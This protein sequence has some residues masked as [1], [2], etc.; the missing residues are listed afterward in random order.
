MD[1]ENR[2]DVHCAD[3]ED[4]H[5]AD[6]E[7]VHCADSHTPI[8]EGGGASRRLHTVGQAPSAPAPLCGFLHG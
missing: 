8:H 5:C 2:E 3:R 6:R 4:V 1:S 7:D